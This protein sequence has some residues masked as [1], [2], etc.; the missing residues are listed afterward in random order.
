MP[1]FPA[2]SV[3]GILGLGQTGL[4]H[5]GTSTHALSGM[6]TESRSRHILKAGAEFRVI[7]FNN[8]QNGAANPGFS[9]VNSWTQ[10]PNPSAASATAGYAFA[11]FLVG[12]VGGS[13]SPPAAVAQQNNYYAAYVQDDFKVTPTLTVN[14]GLRYEYETPRTDRFN[15]LTNFDSTSPSAADGAGAGP[16]RRA[17]FR[18][19][20]AAI[21]GIN[22]IPDRNN[23]GPRRASP[24][25][26][27]PRW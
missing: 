26:S 14:L 22:R 13:V 18:R 16:A 17:D 24:G 25:G 4:I 6:L 15:Q 23:I 5:E 21:P 1:L 11:S 2:I 7:Q 19:C 27:A 10:G 20:R 8:Q 3:T 12:A 9:A